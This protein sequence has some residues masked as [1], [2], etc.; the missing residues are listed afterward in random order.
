MWYF[1]AF[2][3]FDEMSPV[4][5][6]DFAR[7][8]GGSH[9][10]QLTSR[11][12]LDKLNIP[13]HVPTSRLSGGQKQRLAIARTIA[14]NPPII[15][16]DEPT[17]GLDPATGRQVA[18]LIR[19]THQA[20]GETTLV[21]TH[22]YPALMPIADNIFLLDPGQQKLRRIDPGE[23]DQIPGMLEAMSTSFR[24]DSEDADSKPRTSKWQTVAIRFLTATTHWTWSLVVGLLSLVPMWKNPWW[25]LRFFGHYGRLV[26]GPTA[27]IYLLLAG[28]ING[29]VTTYFTFK[30]LPFASYTEPLL[31]EDLLTGLGFATYR[32]FVPI[33]ACVLVAARCGAAV[34]SD[35]G[36]RQYG[37]QIRCPQIAGRVSTGVSVDADPVGISAGHA[38]VIRRILR[39]SPHDQSVHFR[40][41]APGE[42]TRFLVP[43]FPPGPDR[44]R[45]GLVSGDGLATGQTAGMRIR[46]RADFLS[47]GRRQKFS[48]SDVS[49]SI[50]TTI[51]LATL[52]VLVV[53]FVFSF[54]EFEGVVPGSRS[55]LDVEPAT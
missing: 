2:A 42:G 34:T 4:A 28:I 10:S 23:W 31:I 1:Q 21:V 7:S 3:L 5:N 27:W 24:G 51:L 46:H 49:R 6:V 12:L 16:Y 52:Y 44:A 9:A 38:D 15:V 35:I 30:F 54:Y 48:S 55:R 39:G 43:V 53:H 41:V 13:A 45:A 22:D 26:F 14:Y 25:G 47:R 29:F 40:A 8:C 17:S 33:L 19:E 20:F 37:H 36:G 50:T 32:I 11:Q 18:N